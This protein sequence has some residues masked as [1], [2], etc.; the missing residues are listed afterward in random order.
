MKKGITIFSVMI[1]A[2]LLIPIQAFSQADVTGAVYYHMNPNRPVPLVDL[3]LID[4]NGNVAA[5]ATTALNGTYL[6]PNVPY[7]TYTLHATTEISAGGVNMADATI[8]F[9]HLLGFYPLNPVQQMAADV[10]GNGSVTW[11]DYWTVVIGWFIQGYPFPAGP[12]V[13]QDVT[14]NHTGAKTNVPVLGGSSSGD[15]NGTFVPTT[16]DYAAIEVNYTE[17]AI[18]SNLVVE[19][20]ANE[21]SEAAAMGMII[22]YPESMVEVTSV[23]SQLGDINY[24]VKNGEIRIN[25]LSQEAAE[26]AVNN[27]LPV[28]TINAETRDNLKGESIRFELDPATHFSNLKGE[29]IGT[30]YT[31]PVFKSTA[32]YLQANYPNPFSGSTSIAYTVP[33]EGKVNV[34]LYNQQGQMV[35][36]LVN[37]NMKAGSYQINFNSAGLEPGVY[38]YTLK[39]NGINSINETKKM[40]IT[41]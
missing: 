36:T 32:G 30:T 39:V 25:W 15:V 9:L 12:W 11:N 38:Y 24:S 4:A 33:A 5:T 35:R 41:R 16:R 10:D 14:F 2:L 18:S 8:I 19:I 40:I 31:L 26:K 34:S 20:S 29:L 23:S 22:R 21:V 27:N 3:D 13:F 6:F 17:T 7:G 28:V 1:S 37:D